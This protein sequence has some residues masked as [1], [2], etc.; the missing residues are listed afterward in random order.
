MAMLLGGGIAS[1]A[2]AR[3]TAD[4]GYNFTMSDQGTWATEGRLKED[5]SA[6]YIKV[7]TKTIPSC[8]VYVDA[9]TLFGW[10]NETVWG[11]ATAKARGKF[12]IHQNVYENHGKCSARLSAWAN[13]GG[14]TLAGQWSPDSW[15]TYP[16]SMAT[17]CILLGLN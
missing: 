15:G 16:P 9:R 10:K 5:S 14:G 7:D 12:A 1:P 2:I 11:Y 4:S 3:T 6:T 8:R 13:N 17:S